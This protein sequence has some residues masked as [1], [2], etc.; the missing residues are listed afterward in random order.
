MAIYLNLPV[1]MDAPARF[2]TVFYKGQQV[3]KEQLG[4]SAHPDMWAA[5][6]LP[7]GEM[8]D[9]TFSLSGDGAEEFLPLVQLSRRRLGEEELYRE[10]MRPLNHFSPARGFMNDPNGL[11]FDGQQ[12]HM[13]FQLNPF[14]LGHGN[15]HWGHAVSEDLLHW[16]EREPALCPDDRDGLI[17]SG[18]AV[19][20]RENVSGLGEGDQ[21]PVLLFYTATGMRYRP[22]FPKDADGKPIFPKDWQRPQT[23]QCV[24]YSVDG[25]RT[26]RKYGPVV[27]Q[28]VPMNRDPK[29]QWVPEAGCWVMALYLENN[30]YTLL[31]SDDLLH[32]EQGETM[33]LPDTAECPD[34][35]RLYLDG[36]RDKP[37]WVYF[38]S[39]E[40]YLVGQ[41]E[42]RHFVH[43]QLIKGCTQL[44]P[45][46]PKM[47]TDAAAYAPQTF[48]GTAEG[49]VLQISWLPTR[50]PGMSFASCMSLPWKLEL[51]STPEGPRLY[52]TPAEAVAALREE[53]SSLSGDFAEISQS[54]SKL[55][56]DS[57]ELYARLAFEGEGALTLSVRG[58]LISIRDGGQKLLFPT[59][60]Y[61]LPEKGRGELRIFADRGSIELF[62]DGFACALNAPL[63][64][65]R[66]KVELLEMEGCRLEGSLYRLADTR[67]EN[68]AVDC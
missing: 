24:A 54:L 61:N 46:G 23:D 28:I 50:F 59:G 64:P 9:Y 10:P 37:Y 20:D 35:F 2:V 26:F 19:I 12:Y 67:P 32:W 44:T 1:R 40:N 8:E 38:G 22:D 58:V 49:E 25:G 42:G 34:I 36:D 4:L 51:R 68:R 16:T 3:G 11:Y 43:G 14:G 17:F 31:Y 57:L 33:T 62:Y 65:G 13:F 27:P 29:V 47:F 5:L 15:T 7:D 60:V 53:E 66:Q 30:D 45:G 39:P 41:F 52:K 56:G 6:P 18:S 55:K 21:P 48:F 63:D